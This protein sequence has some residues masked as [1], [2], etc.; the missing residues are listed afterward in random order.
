M[1]KT[2]FYRIL[3]IVLVFNFNGLYCQEA[4]ENEHFQT[5]TS[6][7]E[8]WEE[9][10][11]VREYWQMPNRVLDEIGV[12]SGHTI[13]DVGCGIGYF[14]F[15]LANKVGK[16]GYV[17]ASDIDP[18][19]LEF[20]RE[21][22]KRQNIQNLEIIQGKEDDPLLPDSS[23]DIVLI[24][25]TVHLIDRP[26]AYISNL[27]S[28]LKPAGCVVI[29]QWDAEKMDSEAPDWSAEDREKYTQQT[30]LRIIYD[31][32]YEVKRILDFLPVQLIYVCS[33]R[34]P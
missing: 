10:D 33:P 2:Q 4:H 7:Y 5:C 25:N 29:V 26:S 12:E 15:R 21:K 19:A 16:S 3:S 20:L 11:K 28:C 9:R 8:K 27:K 1:K 13:A 22:A 6:R 30:T 24:V 17:Y 31:A 32:G 18:G 23:I 14:S 34:I